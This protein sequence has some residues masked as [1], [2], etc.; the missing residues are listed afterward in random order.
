MKKRKTPCLEGLPK[1][2]ANFDIAI[3]SEFDNETQGV[4]WRKS[5]SSQL[6]LFIQRQELENCLN[7]L[8]RHGYSSEAALFVLG[9]VQLAG[10]AV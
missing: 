3:I 6:N 8:E 2:K 9:C 10:G 4:F 1:E 7:L 5:A